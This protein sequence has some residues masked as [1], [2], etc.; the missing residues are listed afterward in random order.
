[1]WSNIAITNLDGI[2]LRL[3]ICKEISW[4]SNFVRYSRKVFLPQI[5]LI[6]SRVELV[7]CQATGRHTHD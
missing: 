4:I 1:V 6:R 7:W 2:V 3:E 5:R